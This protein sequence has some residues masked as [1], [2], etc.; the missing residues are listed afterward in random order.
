MILGFRASRVLLCLF[1]WAGGPLGS[2]CA[3]GG[4]SETV[5]TGAEMCRAR[6]YGRKTA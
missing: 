3:V 4:A 1:A 2:P 6:R 5:G